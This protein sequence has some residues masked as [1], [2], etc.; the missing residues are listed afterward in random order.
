[1]IVTYLNCAV[2]GA[3]SDEMLFFYI[4][5]ACLVEN[6]ERVCLLGMIDAINVSARFYIIR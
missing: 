3:K 4:H 2:L 5:D 6:K 1:M